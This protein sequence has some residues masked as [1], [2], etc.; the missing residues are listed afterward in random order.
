MPQTHSAPTRKPKSLRPVATPPDFDGHPNT[1]HRHTGPQQRDQVFRYIAGFGT[2][3]A[4][5]IIISNHRTKREQVTVKQLADRLSAVFGVRKKQAAILM[6][7]SESALSRNT[8]VSA[9]M[10]DRTLQASEVF[11]DV[12]SVLGSA[13]ARKWF[14]TPNPALENQA[15]V[16]LLSSRVGEKRVQQVI[17]A[18]LD[19][20]YL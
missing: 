12:V 5:A 17:G 8:D 19:G 7:V 6:G 2:H 20:A 14:G 3:E 18:L 16:Q 9:D 11:A 1:P 10:L 15:P 4:E 13:Q